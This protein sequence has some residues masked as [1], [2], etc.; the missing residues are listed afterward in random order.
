MEEIDFCSHHYHHLYL[1]DGR[2]MVVPCRDQ[3][4]CI[5]RGRLQLGGGVSMQEA[6]CQ[7][8]AYSQMFL[9]YFFHRRDLRLGS[10]IINS[11]VP[12]NWIPTGRTS[13]S[14]NQN[15]EWM[16]SEDMLEVWNRVWITDNPWMA[17]KTR[18]KYWSSIPY[19]HKTADIQCGSLIGKPERAKWAKN[20]HL[21]VRNLRNMVGPGE[22][23]KDYLFSYN[24][25]Q[26]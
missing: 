24:R 2:K 13:W 4:E 11:G 12:I 22:Q 3:Y 5:G 20:A 1:H 8:K 26:A 7:A 9:L 15:Y 21:H 14:V 23:Y 18:I 10:M 25:Y 19:L 6:A 16:T 17:D